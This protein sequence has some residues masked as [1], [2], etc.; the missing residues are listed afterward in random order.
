MT[1]V[2]LNNRKYTTKY[3]KRCIL[4]WMQMNGYLFGSEL[5]AEVFGFEQ[6]RGGLQT[7]FWPAVEVVN[8]STTI[9]WELC[10]DLGEIFSTFFSS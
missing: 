10:R 6:L 5:R 1:Q 9:R 7:S 4:A 3:T 2:L 8:L